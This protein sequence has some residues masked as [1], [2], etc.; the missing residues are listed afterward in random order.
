MRR[1]EID[2]WCGDFIIREKGGLLDTYRVASSGE[3]KSI[4]FCL[5][6]WNS[7]TDWTEYGYRQF[8]LVEAFG[9]WDDAHRAAFR[10]WAEKPFFP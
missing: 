1:K 8:N 2:D 7:W 4:E 6:V 5:N 3:R 9:T 10:S